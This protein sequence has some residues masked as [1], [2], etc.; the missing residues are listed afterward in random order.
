MRIIILTTLSA[1]LS[2]LLAACAATTTQL[3]RGNMELV[4]VAGDSCA[5]FEKEYT[6]IQLELILNNYNTNSGQHITGYLSGT[7][8][9]T[10]KLSG[11]DITKLQ[12]MYP[13]ESDLGAQGHTLLLTPTPDGG[14]NGELHE[15]PVDSSGCYFINAAI[16]VKHTGTESEAKIAFDLQQNMFAAE[17]YFHKGLA[18]LKAN[19]PEKA[20]RDFSESQKLRNEEYLL[21]Q[22]SSYR[23]FPVA[24][25]HM[26]AG[27]PGN[28][29]EILRNLLNEKQLTE[30]ATRQMH[31]G[32]IRNL[33]AYTFEAK[34]DV[35]K[36]AAEQLL[37][38]LANDASG[39][40]ED[41]AF[42]AECYR[43]LGRDR[44]VQEEPDESIEY[45][46]KALA[47]DSND[48]DSIA[49]IVMSYVTKGSLTEGRNFLQKHS[50]V[51][52]AKTGSENYNAGLLGLYDTESRQAEKEHDYTRAEQLLREALIISPNERTLIIH[53]ATVLEKVEKPDEARK[54]LE[55]ASSNCNDEP[56]RSDYATALAR[57]KQIEKIVDRLNMER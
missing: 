46:Q 6:H 20:L 55:T 27:R 57:Q 5:E 17:T 53:L 49:G 19:N 42:F 31:F 29:L 23:A 14:I 44:I 48:A 56:C 21:N 36:K 51:M 9:Q 15:K 24:T 16:R 10:G 30:T 11:S 8:M 22:N 26:M 1:I 2:S 43:E 35:R 13:D 45:F 41:K 18:Q 3:Y 4:S 39:Q 34:E 52:I 54:L 33:C 12:V 25:A 40:R 32:V 7:D 47:L 50:E 28:A 37:D 38:G